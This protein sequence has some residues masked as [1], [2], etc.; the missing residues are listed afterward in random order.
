MSRCKNHSETH[1]S[2]ICATNPLAKRIARRVSPRNITRDASLGKSCH[3]SLGETHC[4]A[5][6]ATRPLAK[7]SLSYFVADAFEKHIA[8]REVYESFG[9][10]HC[11][12]MFVTNP[13][14]KRIARLFCNESLG[15]AHRSATVA[16]NP[17]AKQ[18]AQRCLSRIPGRSASLSEGRYESLGE[19]P[20]IARR[21]LL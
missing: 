5:R 14:A 21:G 19:T 10:T 9:E 18:N 17:L 13:Y 8:R 4:P 6:V 3:E 15:E 16:T 11:S 7:I 1:R 2:N 20:R 12:A